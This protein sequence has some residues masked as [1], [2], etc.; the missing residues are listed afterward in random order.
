MRYEPVGERWSRSGV[1]E[2][3]DLWEL[4]A[5]EQRD[6]ER[7]GEQ[8]CDV[9]HFK[10][11][12]SEVI[13]FLRA[14]SGNLKAAESM[15]RN[16]I[17]WRIENKVDT[18][19]QWYRPP[20]EI[21]DHY[22]GSILQGH[23][24]AGDPIFIERLGVTDGV[25]ML[26]RYGRHELIHHAIWLRELVSTGDWIQHYQKRQGRA[27]RQ[28][29]IMEDLHGL[30]IAH[31][32]RQLLS[33]YAE[34]MRIDQDC[35]PEVAKQ[36]IIIRAPTIFRVI[37]IIAKHFFDPGVLAGMI[38]TGPNNYKQV[39]SEHFDLEILP[40]VIVPE[41][42]GQA[43][44]G[45]PLPGNFEGGPLPPKPESCPR[46]AREPIIIAKSIGKGVF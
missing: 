41:G 25:G 9:A 30:S 42:K 7:L 4:S 11:T 20:R 2:V 39:L 18:I 32:N 36:M 34:I 35:Y 21:L 19:L 1:K 38:F 31:M 22:P 16:M 5:K 12:P 6:L 43:A 14:R 15:F 28:I 10:N 33:V 40:N 3:V 26:E 17:Q 37:W 44:E 8:L 27:V 24:K 13:R 23:D 46:Q 45:L 29:T